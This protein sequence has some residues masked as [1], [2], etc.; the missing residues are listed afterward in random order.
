MGKMDTLYYYDP[1]YNELL[2]QLMEI[3]IKKG[4]L[5]TSKNSP[6]NMG[7]FILSQSLNSLQN[8][9]KDSYKWLTD[10][11]E[12]IT[13]KDF[14]SSLKSIATSKKFWIEIVDQEG[15]VGYF[16]EH[17][18]GGINSLQFLG[19][20]YYRLTSSESTCPEELVAAI[21]QMLNRFERFGHIYIS[22]DQSFKKQEDL[23]DNIYIYVFFSLILIELY[24][25]DNKIQYLNTA[26]L[27]N[28]LFSSLADN[29][30]DAG[31]ATAVTAA[32]AQVNQ[33]L[34]D[35]YANR[36]FRLPVN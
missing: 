8:P 26:L 20:A 16:S 5:G 11:N 28:D 31:I 23:Y 1:H 19:L 15:I 13:L 22:Y 32:I 29:I 36:E 27:T 24:K 2:S 25:R 4:D 33:Q 21:G 6:M 9:V 3:T 7:A 35:F 10:Y 18:S 34:E 17:R 30:A 14:I 12:S